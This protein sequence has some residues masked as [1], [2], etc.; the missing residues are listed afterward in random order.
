MAQVIVLTPE[1]KA[2]VEEL[3]RGVAEEVIVADDQFRSAAEPSVQAF[4]ELG[5]DPIEGEF[6]I[7]LLLFDLVVKYR[8]EFDIVPKF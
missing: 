1:S 3:F 8:L 4:R 7:D 2:R 5:I 6:T